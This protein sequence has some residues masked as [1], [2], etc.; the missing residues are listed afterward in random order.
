MPRHPDRR[1]LT[2]AE[3]DKCRDAQ[4]DYTN[5]FVSCLG[6]TAD[7]IDHCN[8]RKD[9]WFDFRLCVSPADEEIETL[10]GFRLNGKIFAIG[11]DVRAEAMKTHLNLGSYVLDEQ[12]K[13]AYD[14]MMDIEFENEELLGDTQYIMDTIEAYGQMDGEGRYAPF[15][16]MLT[17]C[18][19]H[20]LLDPM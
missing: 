6:E 20:E 13:A 1:V 14:T 3:C 5:L 15:C 17:Y 2:Q 16:S 11:S 12:R 4:M 18:L 10:F 9:N 7:T 19:E 8:H